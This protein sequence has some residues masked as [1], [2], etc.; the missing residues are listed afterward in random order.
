[1]FDKSRKRGEEA[2]SRLQPGVKNASWARPYNIRAIFYDICASEP[3]EI[4]MAD[5]LDKATRQSSNI[6]IQEAHWTASPVRQYL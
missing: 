5:L 2:C 4:I 6:F 3:V 1:M